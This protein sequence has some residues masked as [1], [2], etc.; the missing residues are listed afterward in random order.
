M[1]LRAVWMY[2]KDVEY[3]VCRVTCLPKD[4]FRGWA[5]TLQQG[6]FNSQVTV[7]FL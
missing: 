3:A 5:R 4:I 7:Y 6:P 2:Y 1:T